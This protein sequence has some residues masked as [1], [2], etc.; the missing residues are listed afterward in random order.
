MRVSEGLRCFFGG[1]ILLLVAL[2]A[3]GCLS[4]SGRAGGPLG[5]TSDGGSWASGPVKR[6]QFLVVGVFT[7]KNESG[8]EV[9]LES[10][11]PRD[12][13]RAEG[14]ELRYAAVQAPT[15]GCQVGALS[16]WPPLGCASKIRP[17]KGFRIARGAAETEILVGARSQHLGRWF[18]PAFRLRYSVGASH[19][20]TSYSQGIRVRVVRRLRGAE[21]SASFPSFQTEAHNIGC[22]YTRS[23]GLLRCEIRTGLK[24][25]CPGSSSSGFEMMVTGPARPF[26][27]G[28][29]P[30]R[31]AR[32]L[33]A[34][35]SWLYH[36]FRCYAGHSSI[37][38]RNQVFKGFFLSPSRSR[39]T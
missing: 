2:S 9:V 15:R 4:D 1:L 33:N 16:N 10:I 27:G 13:D 7:R 36:G 17:V 5:E 25:G 14:L 22:A 39:S 37:R 28:Q 11:E 29:A 31:S 38:C 26:C 34:R 8:H 12:P 32:V 18:I 24:E 20:E 21:S 19:Y 3:A 35:A 30:E 23:T 6:G